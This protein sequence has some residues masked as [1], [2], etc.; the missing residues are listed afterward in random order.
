MTNVR[1]LL[2]GTPASGK[3]SIIKELLKVSE[4][5]FVHY[6]L[7]DFIIETAKKLNQTGILTDDFIANVTDTFLSKG[8]E[9]S[10]KNNSIIEF[11]HHDYLSLLKT[12]QLNL[13]DFHLIVLSNCPLKSLLERNKKRTYQ[14]PEN[15]IARCYGSI[16]ALEEWLEISR[17]TKWF[18]IDTEII[19]PIEANNLILDFLK[20]SKPQSRINLIENFP[21]SSK[22]YLG[23][24]FKNAIEWDEELVKHLKATFEVKTALDVGC[25]LGLSIG[26]FKE[27]GIDCW[28]LEGN[29][30]IFKND[31]PNKEQIIQ[32]DFIYQWLNL[33]AKFDLVWSVEVC[34][35]IPSEFEDN[36]IKTIISNCKK[37]IFFSAATPEQIG[38]FHVNCRPKEYWIEKFKSLGWS[39]FEKSD[40]L[41]NS[42]GNSGE[43]GKNYLKENGLVLIPS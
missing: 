26:L 14:V 9:S 21:V 20:R 25:G 16:S 43:F 12:K 29:Q 37:V 18:K 40:S 27:F 4:Y 36:V 24:H 7:D 35:H 10:K 3:S 42:L 33:P 23:G 28:G 41:L 11:P 22:P 6:N 32:I 30:A 13:D 19:K 39:L 8:I 5:K 17:F 15:Y 34:E 1:I 2:I 38:Y 31:I